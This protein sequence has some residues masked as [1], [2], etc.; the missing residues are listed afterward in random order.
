MKDQATIYDLL[1]YQRALLEDGARFLLARWS[2][3]TGKSFTTALLAVLDCLEHPGTLW[4]CLS[5]GE[6][7]S[8]EW[9]EKARRHC[10]AVRLAAE[11]MEERFGA[12]TAQ[13][14]IR[15]ANGSRIIG[16]PANPNTARGYSG[17]VILDEFAFHEDSRGI[18][19][20]LVPAITRG[21]RL[22][23]CSTPN[24]VGNQ[25]HALCER[26]P[27]C[28]QFSRHVVTLP[29]AAAQGLRVDT[30][31]LR[32]AVD[33]D[34]WR[35]EYLCE[36]VDSASAFLPYDLITP[37]E[38]PPGQG[39]DDP[40]DAFGPNPLY[41]GVDVGR[42]H[43]L[44]V[45]WLAEKA[46]PAL[47]TR[48]VLELSRMPFSDQEK[49]LWGLLETPGLRR[50]C[51]DATGLGMQLC[52]RAQERFGKYT[53]E[54]VT[55]SAP[56]KE[57]LAYPLRS[58]MEDRAVRVPASDAIRDD[59][60]RIRRTVTAAGNSRFDAASD[61]AG[62]ADRFWALA[63]CLHASSG[64]SGPV[65]MEPWTADAGDFRGE[66]NTPVNDDDLY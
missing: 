16:L 35:Q 9:M 41:L 62:H 4:V 60:H 25:F 48:R 51:M 19:R 8:R 45:L 50:C 54:A 27:L 14:T 5:A 64:A 7:Q 6:R 12:D 52:E 17:N 20:A 57:A 11:M 31:A 28:D 44:T 63:L 40:R 18:W 34:T 58:A 66:T 43:D 2:R 1:P 13:L 65:A 3:Q 30:A 15:M 33:E 47:V 36:F 39:L 53:V 38:L 10:E 55:F 46:G 24:G 32:A 29:D 56:V 49:V 26:H 23:V 61:D 42:R 59:L 22:V 21:Y 37:C